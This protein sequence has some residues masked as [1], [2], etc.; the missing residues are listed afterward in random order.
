MSTVRFFQILLLD[1]ICTEK[2]RINFSDFY[3]LLRDHLNV[4]NHLFYFIDSDGEI[5]APLVDVVH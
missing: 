3:L 4:T 5:L 1:N 2:P